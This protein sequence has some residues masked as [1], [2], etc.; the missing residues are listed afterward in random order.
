MALPCLDNE[1]GKKRFGTILEEMEPIE[2]TL[3]ASPLV[4][5]DVDLRVVALRK[6][7]DIVE[8]TD[9]LDCTDGGRETGI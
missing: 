9:R 1:R 4:L 8:A 3:L 6:M 5:S 2:K 7:P